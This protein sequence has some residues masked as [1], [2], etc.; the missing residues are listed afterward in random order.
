[1]RDFDV[2]I[3]LD[4]DGLYYTRCLHANAEHDEITAKSLD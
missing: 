4:L 3:K 2:T 1:M